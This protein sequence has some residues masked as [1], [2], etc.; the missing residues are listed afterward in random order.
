[1]L[2]CIN[3]GERLYGLDMA[4]YSHAE[5]S[6]SMLDLQGGA[7]AA[8][9]SSIDWNTVLRAH[10]AYFDDCL[11]AAR[12]PSWLQRR[13]ALD[14]L[15]SD[16]ASQDP[17]KQP[18]LRYLGAVFSPSS[19]GALVAG[20]WLGVFAPAASAAF[21]ADDRVTANRQLTRVA[22]ALALHRNEHGDYPDK[23]D[24]VVPAHLPKPPVD[25]FHN[26]PLVYHKTDDGYLLFSMGANGQDDGGSN[27]GGPWGEAKFEGV[28]VDEPNINYSDTSEWDPTTGEY[29]GLREPEDEPDD[30]LAKIPLGADDLSFRMPP[31]V[32][33]WPW[34][35]GDGQLVD[36][37]AGDGQAGEKAEPTAEGD[38]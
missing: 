16:V 31:R 34:E 20:A 26:H 24:A 30:P 10:N 22:I 14:S 27:E 23:L 38:E 21:A 2:D 36:G 12:Q 19:R 9:W 37:Q 8:A 5:G 35:V 18:A 15:E 25:L 7:K 4:L 28:A 33:P 17:A 13:D 6:V 11:A 29:L 32:D 1:M 3:N